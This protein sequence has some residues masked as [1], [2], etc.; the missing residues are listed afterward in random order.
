MAAAGRS[1]AT[2]IV[3]VLV[4]LAVSLGWT[5]LAVAHNGVGASFQGAAGRYTV[6]AYDG[7]KLPSGGLE[8]RLVLLDAATGEP[9]DGVVPVI[10]ARRQGHGAAALSAHVT[11]MANV[12]LYDLPNPYPDDWIVTVALS[13]SLGRGRAT[14]P[15]HGF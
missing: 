11:V 10:T 3:A 1:C 6:Y 2:V 12:V 15:M 14:F 13:G 4:W 9:A 8:Y 7:Y 5:S